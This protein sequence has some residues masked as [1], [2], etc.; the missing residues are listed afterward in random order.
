MIG[1]IIA[2]IF[3]ALITIVL[4]VLAIAPAMLSSQISQE[5]EE[6]NGL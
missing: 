5:E 4:G 1:V 6:R 2:W 3:I